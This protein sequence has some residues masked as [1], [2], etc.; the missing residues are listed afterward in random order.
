MLDHVSTCH[1]KLNVSNKRLL[2]QKECL[3][4]Q[5][6]E[7]KQKY[8]Q[9]DCNKTETF[10]AFGRAKTFMMHQLEKATA[11]NSQ[12]LIEESKRCEELHNIN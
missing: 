8:K 2:N 9:L 1:D 4:K 12:A 11:E 5:L 6:S 3:V 10:K 7:M